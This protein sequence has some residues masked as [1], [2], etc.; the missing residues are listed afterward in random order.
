MTSGRVQTPTAQ[1]KK[2]AK[3]KGHLSGM[4]SDV[5]CSRGPI[6]LIAERYQREKGVSL[7]SVHGIL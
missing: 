1:A 6:D 7:S 4:Q 5:T 3:K 2:T